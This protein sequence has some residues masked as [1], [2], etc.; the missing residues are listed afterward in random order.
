MGT[1]IGTYI[2]TCIIGFR[3]GLFV[4]ISA[5]MFDV[6]KFNMF[7]EI[8]IFLVVVAFDYHYLSYHASYV[9]LSN[10]QDCDVDLS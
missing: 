5:Y 10:I 4:Y 8:A 3:L 6:S 9:K 1:N 7:F 2:K